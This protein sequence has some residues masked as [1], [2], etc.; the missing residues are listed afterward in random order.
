MPAPPPPPP[1]APRPDGLSGP[2]VYRPGTVPG[3]STIAS[4]STLGSIIGGDV[5]RD[6]AGGPLY[7]DQSRQD[8]RGRC[9]DRAADAAAFVDA[10]RAARAAQKAWAKVPAPARGRV[11]AQVGRLVEANKQALSS[12]SRGGRQALRGVARRGAGDHRHLRLLHRRRAAPVRADGPVG[13]ARQAALHVPQPGRRG[14]HH[15]RRQLPRGGPD[16]VPGPG[17]PVRQRGRVEAGRVRVGAGRRAGQAIPRRRRAG[18]RA[19]PRPGQRRGDVQGPAAL[20]RGGPRGQGRLHR[21]ERRRRGIGGHA[22][23]TCSPPASSS[24]ARTRWS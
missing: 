18:R 6:G 5:R 15:H 2:L 14:G 19:E 20:A 11:I 4:G 17:D 16:L 9:G 13:D 8:G 7:V 21:L 1:V 23:A 12:S 22:A 24:A 10:A 3:M